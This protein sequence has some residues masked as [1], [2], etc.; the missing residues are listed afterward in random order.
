MALIAAA[1]GGVSLCASM[2]S[3]IAAALTGDEDPKKPTGPTGPTGPTDPAK[4]TL[5]KNPVGDIKT[6]EDSQL[7]ESQ[8]WRDKNPGATIK[9]VGGGCGELKTYDDNVTYP[10]ASPDNYYNYCQNVIK[11]KECA[12]KNCSVPQIVGACR[13]ECKPY[14]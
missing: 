7:I 14:I 1:I 12:I 5:V 13:D 6:V 2:S 3:S 8:E 4:E 9:D 11:T 10:G